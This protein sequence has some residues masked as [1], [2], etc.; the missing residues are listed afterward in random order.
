[1]TTIAYKD[2][3]IAYDSR[4]TSDGMIISDEADKKTVKDGVV[5]FFTG[6][7]CD[8]E[9]F[10]RLYFG[11]DEQHKNVEC[12]AIIV[13]KGKVNACSIDDESGMFNSPIDFI[14][15][16]A[17]GSGTPHAYT[18]M[19]MGATAVEA[20]KMAAKRDTCTGG[21]VRTFKVKK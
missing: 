3:I 17:I 7:T 19:D 15:G 16:Y 8:E 12:S 5:F 11:S 10:I 20:V 21:R 1:M 18:A 14:G 9:K 6:A 13:D 4:A 2:G